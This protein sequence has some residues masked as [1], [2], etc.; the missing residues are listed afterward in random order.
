MKAIDVAFDVIAIIFICVGLIGLA[1][2][3]I[4]VILVLRLG[5]AEYGLTLAA[6]AFVAWRINIWWNRLTD[7][8]DV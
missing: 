3:F 5:L 7:D 6:M 1:V 4:P 8:E 2:A